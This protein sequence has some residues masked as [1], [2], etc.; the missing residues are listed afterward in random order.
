MLDH[1]GLLHPWL[2][3]PVVVNRECGLQRASETSG[4]NFLPCCGWRWA[5]GT[6]YPGVRAEGDQGLCC[7]TLPR[8]S[9]AEVGAGRQTHT[10]KEV[11]RKARHGNG[12]RDSD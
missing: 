7:Q 6:L 1:M 10:W 2:T 3:R 9:Q 12:A 11:T 8:D 5:E 4:L